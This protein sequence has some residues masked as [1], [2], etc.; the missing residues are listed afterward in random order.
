M[1]SKIFISVAASLSDQRMIFEGGIYSV[2]AYDTKIDVFQDTFLGLHGI[3]R[4]RLRKKVF[5]FHDEVCDQ[6]GQ[7][8]NQK[9]LPDEYRDKV[10]QHIQSFPARESY[11]SR[12][13]N[14]LHLYLDSKLC[15]ADMHRM[16]IGEHPELKGKV[17]EWVYRDIFDYEFNISFGFTRSNICDTCE[18]FSVSIKKQ[19]LTRTLTKWPNWNLN[20]IS[21]KLKETPSMLSW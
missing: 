15:V 5:N 2:V 7:H 10:R 3:Q 4:S 19:R 16:F 13:Q 12:S 1:T 6:R 14:R 17:L 20:M 8:G 11:Y 18:K 9:K 21:T